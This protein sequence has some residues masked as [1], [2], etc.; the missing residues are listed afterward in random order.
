MIRT[1]LGETKAVA[2]IPARRT[3]IVLL[4]R[5]RTLKFNPYIKGLN[6]QKNKFNKL[7]TPI[8]AWPHLNKLAYEQAKLTHY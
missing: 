3:T 6:I 7:L 8:L 4:P 2:R 1:T 5:Q